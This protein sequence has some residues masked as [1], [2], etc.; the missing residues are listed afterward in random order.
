MLLLRRCCAAATQGSVLLPPGRTRQC[1]STWLLL[2]HRCCSAEAR[3]SAHQKFSC[4]P[5]PPLPMPPPC[6]ADGA[7]PFSWV[8]RSGGPSPAPSAGTY[9]KAV[10]AGLG[11][12]QY[13]WRYRLPAGMTCERC[14]LWV[15]WQACIACRVGMCCLAGRMGMPVRTVFWVGLLCGSWDECACS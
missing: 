6:R 13:G 11:G 1:H 2:A 12:E 7:D 9:A 3:P 10:A 14:V 8:P 4:C 5:H 15:S